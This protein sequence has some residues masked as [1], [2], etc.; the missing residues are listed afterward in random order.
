METDKGDMRADIDID[1]DLEGV[2]VGVEGVKVEGGGV[3]RVG[4]KGVE[5][6]G[7]GVVVVMGVVVTVD[8]CGS[9]RDSL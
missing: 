7:V 4:V 2:K 5:V 6:V 1:I 3:V 9:G 8:S